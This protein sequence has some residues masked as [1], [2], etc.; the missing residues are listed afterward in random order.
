MDG[1]EEKT[2]PGVVREPP[3]QEK[4]QARVAGF[5]KVDEAPCEK[6]D[7]VQPLNAGFFCLERMRQQT[8]AKVRGSRETKVR[9]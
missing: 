3:D 7:G 6:F 4:I 2:V 5:L 1:F 9:G 8:S